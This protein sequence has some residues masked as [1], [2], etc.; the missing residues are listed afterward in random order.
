MKRRESAGE[1]FLSCVFGFLPIAQNDV[2][3]GQGLVLVPPDE[4]AVRVK[5]APPG[6]LDEL[7][8]L[9]TRVQSFA[10]DSLARGRVARDR[11]V[12]ASALPACLPD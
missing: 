9:R 4:I 2:R 8:I 5:I 10:P 1:R 7:R 3:G 12:S 6:A 11:Q